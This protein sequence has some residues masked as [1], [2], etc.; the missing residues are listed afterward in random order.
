M[1]PSVKRDIVARVKWIQAN[2]R[3]MNE[4]DAEKTAIER[5]LKALLAE[6]TGKIEKLKTDMGNNTV[7]NIRIDGKFY[8]LTQN[9]AGVDIEEFFIQIDDNN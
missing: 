2:R 1:T 6:T 4:M 8:T 5:K 9:S 7:L 3:E